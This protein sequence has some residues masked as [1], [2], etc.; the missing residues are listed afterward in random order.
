[1]PRKFEISNSVHDQYQLL[2]NKDIFVNNIQS[3]HLKSLDQDY[4]IHC[5]KDK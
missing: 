4:S 2:K 3:N 5:D 1:M